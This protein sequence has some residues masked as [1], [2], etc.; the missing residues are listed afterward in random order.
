MSNEFVQVVVV[1]AI[2]LGSAAMIVWTV[3]RPYLTASGTSA[4]CARCDGSS[5]NRAPVPANQQLIQIQR[6]SS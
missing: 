3:A 4:P 6:R 1:T 2:A 5:H